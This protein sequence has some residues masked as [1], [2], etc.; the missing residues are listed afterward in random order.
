[1]GFGRSDRFDVGLICNAI[2]PYIYVT[3]V[4]FPTEVFFVGILQGVCFLLTRAKHVTNLL[5]KIMFTQYILYLPKDSIQGHNT[6]VDSC[7]ANVISY[8]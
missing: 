1:M 2:I 6:V 5:Y 4:T 7:Y 3:F 8:L